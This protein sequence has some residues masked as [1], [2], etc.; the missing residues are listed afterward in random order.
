MDL[1][2]IIPCHNLEKYITPL[3]NSLKAQKH[4][5]E[6]EYIFILD[7]CTDNTERAIRASNLENIKI[8]YCNVHS[9]GLARNIGFENSQGKYIWFIDGDD[10]LLSNTAIQ[11]VLDTIIKE[12]L[13]RLRIKFD[14][15]KDFLKENPVMVWQYI[16]LKDL[17]SNI[18]FK[19]VQPGEDFYFMREV[20]NTE[21]NLKLSKIGKIKEYLYFYNYGRPDSNNIIHNQSTF[22][23]RFLKR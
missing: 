13:N 23:S 20:I 11:L 7:D 17:I 5:Y 1:S 22:G 16:F 3:L 9:C 2:I 19:E 12:D 14:T 8:L 18:K 21:S 10:W 6:V 4:E 15:T